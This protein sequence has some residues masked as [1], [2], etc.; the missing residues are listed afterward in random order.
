LNLFS[1]LLGVFFGHFDFSE[2]FYLSRDQNFHQRL[3]GLA[4]RSVRVMHVLRGTH[5]ARDYFQTRALKADIV[6]DIIYLLETKECMKVT[7]NPALPPTPQPIY[8][9]IEC[10]AISTYQKETQ[11]RPTNNFSTSIS[12]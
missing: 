5:K 8:T 10:N 4:F 9:S 3:L 2:Q 11:L 1:G 7:Y 6:V 12:L